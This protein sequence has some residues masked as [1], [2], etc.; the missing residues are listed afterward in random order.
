MSEIVGLIGFCSSRNS[1]I[2]K[3]I[4]F[5]R[6]DFISYNFIP[7]HSFVILGQIGNEPILGESVEPF[8][9]LC[10]LEKYT[11]NMSKYIELWEITNKDLS[12]KLNAA[13]KMLPFIGKTYG[14]IQLIG[15]I[16][17]WLANKLGFRF[18][19]P[20]DNPQEIVC[21][22]YVWL[23]LRNLGYSDSDLM[24]MKQ[25]D[26]APD[27]ILNSFVNNSNCRKVAVK[28]YDS[29]ELVWSNVD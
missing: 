1:I 26:I 5:F 23:F 7:S 2:S 19:N 27:T 28:A 21:A 18:S 20:I 24:N 16:I 6:K 11:S 8:N 17:P 9:R 22:E 13:E 12:A 29:A 10:P 3:L 25:D 4:S 14:Y 15:Y